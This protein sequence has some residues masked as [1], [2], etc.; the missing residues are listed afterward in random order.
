V[1]L[2]REE[3]ER[4]GRLRTAE[5]WLSLARQMKEAGTLFL[6]LTGGE[7]LIYPDFKRLYLELRN[8][9]MLVTINTNGTL[10]DEE[11]AAFFGAYKPRRINITLY[12]AD[13]Q[14]Y[15][16]L[17]HYP[18]GFEKTVNAVRLL[19]AQ[20]IEVKLGVSLTPKNEKDVARF[21][22][23]G[24][25]LGVHVNIDTYM[26]PAERERSLPF[27][28]QARLSPEAAARG[29]IRAF[30]LMMGRERFTRFAMENVYAAHHMKPDEKPNRM[31]CLAGSCSFTVNWQG[32]MRPCVVMAEPEADVFEMGFDAAWRHIRR[33]ADKIVMNSRCSACPLRALCRTCA[34]GALLETGSYDG[35]PEYLC[36]Y[37]QESLRQLEGFCRHVMQK[38]Q[39]QQINEP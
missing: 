38:R 34:A 37:A 19:R 20:G 25:E 32:K 36:R 5:E 3:M 27:D 29:R 7:P 35:V 16:D 21:Y 1:R 15:A 6:L 9:G 31:S 12:G 23:I 14:A 28:Q 10:I 30:S 17:C 13:E 22:E 4:Q 26:M 24:R 11:W 8:I 39:E 33:E 18:G 2:S